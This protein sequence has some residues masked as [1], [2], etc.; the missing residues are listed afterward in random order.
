M[1]TANTGHE[2]TEREKAICILS[3]LKANPEES[4]TLCK[5]MG[6]SKEVAVQAT[7][8]ITAFIKRVFNHEHD[9]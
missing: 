9:R 7:L 3:W 2:M 5:T 6:I 8:D 4:A 1:T